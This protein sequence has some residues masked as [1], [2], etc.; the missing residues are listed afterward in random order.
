LLLVGYFEGLDA[1]RG[2]ASRAA[3]SLAVRRFVRLGIEEAA[4]DHSTISRTRRQIDS[5]HCAASKADW[6]PSSPSFRR[7]SRSHATDSSRSAA[8]CA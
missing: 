5:A 3:D 8:R 7:S 1:E 6:R 2:I 4:P